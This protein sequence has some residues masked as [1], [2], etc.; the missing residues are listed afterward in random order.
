M[1]AILRNQENQDTI[2]GQVVQ[3]MEDRFCKIAEKLEALDEKFAE[4]QYMSDKVDMLEASV[5]LLENHAFLWP[6]RSCHSA[7]TDGAESSVSSSS[8]Y[9][10]TPAISASMIYSNS[11]RQRSLPKRNHTIGSI[12]YD[13]SAYKVSFNLLADTGYAIEIRPM[14]CFSEF[15]IN[16]VAQR[17]VLC[18]HLP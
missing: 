9:S 3:R 5:R 10:S 13:S 14:Q 16:S 8:L 1:S 6:M 17:Y 11:S 18:L 2:I 7:P 4:V 15:H 12:K